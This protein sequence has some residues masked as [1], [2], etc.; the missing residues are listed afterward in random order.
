MLVV[1][2]KWYR[3]QTKEAKK[4]RKDKMRKSNILL[5]KFLEGKETKKG[6]EVISEKIMD[7]N[8]FKKMKNTKS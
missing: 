4:N 2:K 8:S 7:E 5:I 3:M 1:L 6:A